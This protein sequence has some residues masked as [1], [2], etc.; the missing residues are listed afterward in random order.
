MLEADLWL[1]RFV[2]VIFSSFVLVDPLHFSCAFLRDTAS[3]ALFAI[4]FGSTPAGE[5]NA[6]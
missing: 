5:C 3:S 4:T 1:L 6:L 2:D